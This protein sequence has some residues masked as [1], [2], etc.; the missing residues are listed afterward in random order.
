MTGIIT[1]KEEHWNWLG[2]GV[3]LRVSASDLGVM[4]MGLWVQAV[5]LG[6]IDFESSGIGMWVGGTCRSILVACGKRG[7]LWVCFLCHGS[8]MVG[9]EREEEK[10]T[11]ER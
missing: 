5:R 2:V 3:N 8:A 10:E 11:I 7:S 9:L 6:S 4:G 1:T